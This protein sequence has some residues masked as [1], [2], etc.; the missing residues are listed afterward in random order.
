[1]SL[2]ILLPKA[3]TMANRSLFLFKIIGSPA[4]TVRRTNKKDLSKFMQLFEEAVP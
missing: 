4:A 3:A 1:M 2:R